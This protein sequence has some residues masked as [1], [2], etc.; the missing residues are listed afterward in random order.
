[1]KFIKWACLFFG[2]GILLVAL[3]VYYVVNIVLGVYSVSD[4]FQNSL[5][6]GVLIC[7]VTGIVFIVRDW[8]SRP[9]GGKALDALLPPRERLR[10][11]VEVFV[12][13]FLFVALLLYVNFT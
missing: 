8:I 3:L 12:G 2:L 4:L 10:F 1:M 13:V 5:G 7:F 11:R 6:L 9:R